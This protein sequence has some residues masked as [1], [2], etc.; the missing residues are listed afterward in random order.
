MILRILAATA[1][2]IFLGLPAQA[3]SISPTFADCD[4]GVVNWNGAGVA[5][6]PGNV[7]AAVNLGAPDGASYSLGLPTTGITGVAVFRI[8]P[9]FTGQIFVFDD[10]SAATGDAGAAEAADV[11]VARADGGGAY[12]SSTSFYVGTARNAASGAVVNQF[13]VVGSWDFVYI[14]D[15]SA[16]L[17]PNGGSTNGFDLDAVSFHPVPLPAGGLLLAS[18]LIGVCAA[19][20]RKSRT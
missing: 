20:R 7:A 9:Q 2:A 5:C 6:G 18:A 19:R 4:P 14:Q 8:T 15:A 3:A 11:F 12:D 16:A 17:F 13:A 1:A 10:D